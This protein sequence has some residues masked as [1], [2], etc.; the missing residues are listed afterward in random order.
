[1]T[2]AG[3]ITRLYHQVIS[4][5]YITRLYHQVISSGYI[6]RLYHQ[7]ISKN[8]FAIS[9]SLLLTHVF[10]QAIVLPHVEST[11]TVVV[12]PM[13]TTELR[14]DSFISLPTTGDDEAEEIELQPVVVEIP[15]TKCTIA[16]DWP[17]AA[18]TS[19]AANNC[20][21]VLFA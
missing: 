18:K 4:P 12:S 1:M 20:S 16:A 11:L 9:Y 19:P 13:M 6:T 7:V 17:P 2:S 14:D 8:N 5:G 3:Y 10:L 15:S 21:S